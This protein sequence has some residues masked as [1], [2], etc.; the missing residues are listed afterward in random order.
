G[1][2]TV[3][4]Q[5]AFMG[6]LGVSGSSVTQSP[7]GL[8]TSTL[9]EA[10]DNLVLSPGLGSFNTVDILTSFG[11]SVIDLSIANGYGFSLTNSEFGT[12]EATSGQIVTNNRPDTL[13]LAVTG[14]YKGG[15]AHPT[16]DTTFAALITFTQIQGPS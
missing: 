6:S 3:S 14:T 10:N 1:L 8:N 13:T 4:T 2:S 9:F 7:G 12:F 15:A 11:S 5:A 16:L